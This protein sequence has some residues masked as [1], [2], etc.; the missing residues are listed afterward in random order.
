MAENVQVSCIVKRG[1]H[2]NPHER[3]EKLGGVYSGKRWQMTEEDIIA[4]LLKPDS[5][6]RWNFYVTINGK[7]VWVVVALHEGRRYLKTE[8]DGYSPNNLLALP[9]CP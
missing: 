6:R 8:P 9:E 5:S 1:D 7:A 4:E 2:Y 3:I